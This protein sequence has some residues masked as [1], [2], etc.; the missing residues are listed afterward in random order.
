MTIQWFPGHMTRAKREM[1]EK[2]K[3]MDCVIE[4]RDARCP[5]AS[6]NPLLLDIAQNLPRVLV[7]TKKDLADLKAL[8]KWMIYLK[9][10]LTTVIALD[11]LHDDTRE[12]V[13]EAVLE[14]MQPKIERWKR[15]GIRPRKMKAMILGI[16]NVGKSTLINQLAK[17][18][19][20]VSANRPGVTMSLK[21]ANVHPL[22]DVLDTPGVLWPKFED[23]E[24]GIRL[25]LAGSIREKV[26]PSEKL[27]KIA[28]DFLELHYPHALK[29]RYDFKGKNLEEL[30]INIAKSRHLIKADGYR[31]DEAQ[32]IFLREVKT[33]QLG[34]MCFEYVEDVA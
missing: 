12:R 18:K 14:V 33:G 6:L 4:L 34:R 30:L 3:Q 8:A 27:A 10:E 16:P 17:K 28:F 2:L 22:L 15:R 5:L 21:W 23:Q 31:L 7:L 29:A 9:D 20:M 24:V 26:L 1:Q 11:V 19:L 25:A 13:V 32:E